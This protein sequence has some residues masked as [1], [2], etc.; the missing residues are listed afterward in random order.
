MRTEGLYPVYLIN[1][2]YGIRGLDYRAE[3]NHFGICMLICS[4]F[5]DK[6]TRIQALRRIRRYNDGGNYVKNN[7]CDDIDK[8]KF[9]ELKARIA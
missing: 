3:N 5:P 7:H 1:D 2:D 6:R 9:V 4:P 8:T